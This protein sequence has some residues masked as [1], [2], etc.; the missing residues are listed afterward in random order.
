[1]SFVVGHTVYSCT[2]TIPQM[3][4]T[5]TVKTAQSKRVWHSQVTSEYVV[6]VQIIL[7]IVVQ[8]NHLCFITVICVIEEDINLS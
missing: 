6:H 1:M 8:D 3:F 2:T 4:G 5:S 7:Q